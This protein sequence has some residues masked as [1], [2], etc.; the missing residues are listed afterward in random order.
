MNL[1]RS[2]SGE[3]TLPLPSVFS[4]LTQFPIPND[5][6][7]DAF[8]A[9][10]LSVSPPGKQHLR[11]VQ[12]TV[13]N[14][15]LATLAG[16]DQQYEQTTKEVMDEHIF[17]ITQPYK[18]C[19]YDMM[20]HLR[21]NVD[22]PVTSKPTHFVSHAWST[23]FSVTLAAINAY[24]EET[25]VSTDDVYLWMDVFCLNQ[26]TEVPGSRTMTETELA[27][28]F[29]NSV[30][31]AGHTLFVCTPWDQ[32][33]ALTRCWCL[34]EILETMKLGATF[35]VCLPP[36]ERKRFSDTMVE[37]HEDVEKLGVLDVDV[38][39]AEA[40]TAEDRDMIF[41][42]IEAGSGFVDMNRVV[43]GALRNWVLS[44]G[45]RCL[46][47][48]Q[49]RHGKDS[50][51][52]V[53]FARSLAANLVDSYRLED[54]EKLYNI[55]RQGYDMLISNDISNDTNNVAIDVQFGSLEIGN[56]FGEMRL[57]QRQLDVANEEYTNTM[58]GLKHWMKRD[59]MTH[60]QHTQ[61]E[62]ASLV[63][64][65]GLGNVALK[66]HKY[67][68][69]EYWYTRC[70]AGRKKIGFHEW[71]NHCGTDSITKNRDEHHPDLL[72]VM[73]DLANLRLRQKKFEEAEILFRQVLLGNER[74]LGLLNPRTLNTVNS[75]AMVMK[76]LKRYVEAE[77]FATRA[78]EGNIEQ[79][80]SHDPRTMNATNVLA[81][82]LVALEKYSDAI[83]LLCRVLHNNETKRGVDHKFSMFSRFS[84]A[85]IYLKINDIDAAEPLLRQI[86]LGNEKTEG[87]LG[88]KTLNSRNTL[89][90]ALMQR[91]SQEDLDE[92]GMLFDQLM[93][94]NI[95]V[96][97]CDDF[98][99]LSV[100]QNV[101]IVRKRMTN[102]K[103]LTKRRW[104][105][106]V[107]IGVAWG[108]E[109]GS[110]LWNCRM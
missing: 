99:T 84:L 69:A 4:N 68:E 78:L 104:I 86:V 7:C 102:L 76:R 73:N 46:K 24:C 45:L 83:P 77:K 27:T 2:R 58:N 26:H 107:A 64:M 61:G 51:L 79:L 34:Y 32:P 55:A 57:K 30:E 33:K 93:T 81:Q 103:V 44:A 110:K 106:F 28:C 12:L 17:R 29:A 63:S 50:F 6:G 23:K 97:G 35:S 66:Q 25:E 14:F 53:K 95:Q 87:P 91:G 85:S 65:N 19:A 47:S 67:E 20:H 62:I 108:A 56:G 8:F 5:Q 59:N 75:L 18:A 72:K 52:S 70:I 40:W 31:T 9:A 3:A 74:Q 60:A 92:A 16:L 13:V 11:G 105:M 37:N 90:V 71:N 1:L 109:L 49:K 21:L 39:R 10:P 15:F 98:R 42:W 43:K 100:K 38:R 41:G 82:I 89:A 96:F 48:L 54:A 80:G 94:A 101:I 36:E 22:K 88:S